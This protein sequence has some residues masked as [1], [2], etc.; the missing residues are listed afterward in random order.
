LEVVLKIGQQ[1]LNGEDKYLLD[2]GLCLVCS[3]IEQKEMWGAG[4]GTDG[5]DSAS[6]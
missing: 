6:E 5:A 3:E 1:V 4:V 2:R